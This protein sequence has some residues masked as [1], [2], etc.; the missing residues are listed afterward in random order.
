MPREEALS[1]PT[2]WGCLAGSLRLPEAGAGPWPVVL[3]VG[4]AGPTDRDGN[5]PL[6][7]EPSDNYRRIACALASHGVASLRFDKRGVGE[8]VYPGLS[9]EALRFDQLVDDAAAFGALLRDDSRFGPLVLL[10]HSEGA[11]VAALAAEQAGARLV[12]S[13]DGAGERASH[14]MRRQMEGHLPEDLAAPAMAALAALEGGGTADDVPD[15]LVLLF[16]PSLQA[17]LASW[18]RHDPAEVLARLTMPVLLL[19]G[20]D[21]AQVP[22]EQ[23]RLLQ[24]ARPDAVLRI[25]RGMDH[26]LAIDGDLDAGALRIA[27]EIASCCHCGLDPQSIE[28]SHAS[29]DPGS[30]PG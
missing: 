6:L 26:L 19:H 29:M 12:V 10:G 1:L 13:I 15:A 23:A 9:E 20:A 5:N 16:R 4:G 2:A 21:D 25:I 30:S 11:L 3:L 8:S 17:Y 27:R 14:L 7:Q 28:P 24:A 22:T 18:F